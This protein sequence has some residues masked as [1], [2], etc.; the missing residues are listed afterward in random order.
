MRG[1]KRKWEWIESWGE[2]CVDGDGER[3][4]W[5]LGILRVL[6]VNLVVGVCLEGRDRDSAPLCDSS[7][8]CVLHVCSSHTFGPNERMGGWMVVGFEGGSE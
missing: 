5:C 2:L 6:I 4:G 8:L 1:V 7:Q 3:E